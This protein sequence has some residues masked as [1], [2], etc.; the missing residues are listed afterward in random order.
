MM[1]ESD[2]KDDAFSETE[3]PAFIELRMRENPP[4]GLL[5]TQTAM[6][7]RGPQAYK[8]ATLSDYGREP[9]SVSKRELRLDNYAARRDG[10]GYDFAKRGP[11]WYCENTEIERLRLFLSTHLND[12]G[13]YLLIPKSS[14]AVALLSTL[15]QGGLEPVHLAYLLQGIISR[16][17]FPRIVEMI[18]DP[19]LLLTAAELHTQSK[20]VEDFRAAVL[21]KGQREETYQRILWD[22]WWMLGGRYLQRLDRRQFT[23]LDKLDMALLRLDG[24]M[25]IIELKRAEI[26]SLARKYRAHITVGNEVNEAVNQAANYLRAFDEQRD[27]ILTEF[28]VDCRRA[29]AT[30]II[31]HPSH[32]TSDNLSAKEVREAIRTY[33]SHLSRIEVMTY[34]DL[35]IGAERS[36]SLA[37]ER[38]ESEQG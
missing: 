27:R 16:P 26:P 4:P 30:V 10:P 34:E 6:I 7:K 29:Y 20:V 31:G 18:K 15:E 36:V 9:G 8:I 12:P 14:P 35:V 25:H 3:V 32:N 22:N 11:T 1:G 33:N 23:A 38:I 13:D 2:S 28:N 19:D 21:A 24:V 37:R 17:D 5:T